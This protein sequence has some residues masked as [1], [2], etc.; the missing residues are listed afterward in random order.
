MALESHEF[1]ILLPWVMATQPQ[2]EKR[3]ERRE[4]QTRVECKNP[5]FSRTFSLNIEYF[6]LVICDSGNLHQMNG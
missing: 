3:K 2:R 5:R 1:Y 6:S 4:S